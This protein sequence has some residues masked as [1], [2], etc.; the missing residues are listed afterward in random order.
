MIL[1]AHCVAV[2]YMFCP[3]ALWLLGSLVFLLIL[4]P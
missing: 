3:I 2:V 1:L 4:V